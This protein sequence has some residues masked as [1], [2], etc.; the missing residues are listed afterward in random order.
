ME[1]RPE[2]REKWSD[3]Q[4]L[5]GSADSIQDMAEE[6]NFDLEAEEQARG[7]AGIPEEQAIMEKQARQEAAEREANIETMK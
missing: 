6:F 2:F 7:A 1:A 5:I 4:H 3:L